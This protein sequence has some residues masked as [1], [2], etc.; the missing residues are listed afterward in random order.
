PRTGQE[1][2]IPEKRVATFKPGKVLKSK[3]GS[4]EPQPQS[5]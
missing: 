1:V 2:P 4:T 5:V 3:V